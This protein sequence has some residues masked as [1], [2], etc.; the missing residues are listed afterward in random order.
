MLYPE[1]LK[2]NEYVALFFIKTDKN[3]N[4]VVGRDG[5]IV[6][7]HKYAKNFEEYQDY[8]D[9]FRYNFHAYNALATV[10]AGSDGEPHRRKG[11]MRQQ[12]VLFIDFDK[13]DYP[14]L[15]DVYDFTKMIR[16]KLPNVFLHAYYDSGHGYHYYIIIPPTC[17]IREISEFNKEICALVGA[18]TNACKVT[19]VARIPC[20]FNR[21]NPDEN[22]KFPMVK[23]IDHYRKHPQQ[24]AR[25]HPLNIDN[26]KRTVNN[27][28]KLFTT[29]NIPE[30]PF[31]E[32]K[33]DT[34]GFDIKQY[35]CLC[36]EKVFH[37][38]ADIHE[39]NTWLG[40]IIVWLTR[41]KCPDYKIE[42]MCQEWNTR[43]RPPKSIAE[44]RDE[45]NGW[46][47]WFE[48]HGV[49]KIGGCWW[50]IED[51]R[52]REIVC[53][54]CDKYHCKQAVNP[55][56]SMSI[57]TDVGVKMNEKVLTD[58]KLSVKGKHS[59]SGYEYLILTVLDKYIPKTG[60]KPF[61]VKDLKYRMQYKKHGKWQLCMDISTLKKTMEDLENHKCIKVTDPTPA[62]CKKKNPAFDDKVIKLTRGL[63]ELDMDKY[64]VFYYSVARALICHQITQNEY[65]V[66]LC[67]LN[68]YKNGKSSTLE[69]MS[70]TLNME[71]RNVLRAIQSLEKASLLRVDRLPP[72][73]KGKKYNMYYPVDTDR[74]DE[75]TD[76]E[77]N[78]MVS[79]LSITLI[80]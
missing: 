68:N 39:R 8:I 66:Y 67:I 54:Q 25:F 56:E 55:Y 15:K 41:Q 51:E 27:A 69:K 14:N 23:E 52:K 9:R 78:D 22:G 65:K 75:A 77:L 48:E 24:I 49:E 4:E 76:I 62:Q 3:G 71:E 42:Q 64:I 58:G 20:T 73:D 21:K 19:Q 38:G 45:I 34:G 79:G 26:L 29:E 2:D 5:E 46:Y 36:T 43:C 32:W 10:K 50:N 1:K 70:I 60:R 17:K 47:K 40:R 13:K 30:I 53:K 57:S 16:K 7:F 61:T 28:K 72:N 35:N 37:E 33:Y 31:T 80:A 11:S 59:M 44:T 6:K 74:W 18:D 12:R 63:K